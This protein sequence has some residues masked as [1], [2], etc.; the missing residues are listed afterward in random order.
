MQV[1]C[2]KVFSHVLTHM[3]IDMFGCERFM[4]TF[5]FVSSGLDFS[6]NTRYNKTAII[7][8]ILN[9]TWP[10][11]YGKSKTVLVLD[12]LTKQKHVK[13]CWQ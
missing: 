7:M 12:F 10:Y 11:Q 13:S 2:V 9:S 3:Q 4:F 6:N 8:Q 5:I 1:W